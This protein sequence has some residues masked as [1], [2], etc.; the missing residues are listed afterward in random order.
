MLEDAALEPYAVPAGPG[1]YAEQVAQQRKLLAAPAMHSTPVV[2]LA[3]KR[4]GGLVRV[5]LRKKT[6]AAA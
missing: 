6:E 1:F 3:Q 2:M 4:D 5:A